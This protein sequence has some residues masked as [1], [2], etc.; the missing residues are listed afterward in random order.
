VAIYDAVLCDIDGVLRH[1]PSARHLEQAH[2][3]PAGTLAALAFA[4]HRLQP[5][6]TGQATDEHWR[7]AITTDLAEACGSMTRACAAVTAWSELTPRVDSAVVTLLTRARAVASVALVSNATTRLES[8]LERQGLSNL[9]DIVVN[10]A[11]IGIAKPDARVY[12]IAAQR[13]GAPPNRCLFID[14]TA[15]NA[16]AG[17][18]LGMTAVHYHQIEDLRE[19]LA[20]ILATHQNHDK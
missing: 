5:A 13:V 3:L 15:A 9:A 14:D 18:Q 11:R 17:R 19:A 7:S 20:P 8:D 10:S 4:P 2:D 12:R 6:I 1:W 16:T